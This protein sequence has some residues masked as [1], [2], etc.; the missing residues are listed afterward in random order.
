MVI[1]LLFV[2]LHLFLTLDGEHTILQLDVDVFGRAAGHFG[3]DFDGAVM[4]RDVDAHRHGVLAEFA[5]RGHAAAAE[6]LEDAVDLPLQAGE[7]VGAGTASEY[8]RKKMSG[9]LNL[10]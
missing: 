3:A 1:L 4:L 9:H 8:V 10:Q 7:H 5:E 2:L 6:V